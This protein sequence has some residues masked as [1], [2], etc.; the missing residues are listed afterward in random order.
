MVSFIF[1]NSEYLL[2][3]HEIIELLHRNILSFVI[4][5]AHSKVLYLDQTVL[6]Y[7]DTTEVRYNFSFLQARAED[8]VQN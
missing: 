2:S 4:F 8:I 5:L 7:G 3:L 6:K 1:K